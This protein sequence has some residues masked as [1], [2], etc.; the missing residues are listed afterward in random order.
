MTR[1]MYTTSRVHKENVHFMQRPLL[2][3]II[4]TS[5]RSSTTESSCRTVQR[6]TF[7]LTSLSKYR[8]KKSSRND[9]PFLKGP[10][11][12]TTTTF[13]S[14]TLSSSKISSRAFWLSSNLWSCVGKAIKIGRPPN[15]FASKSGS[16]NV[17]IVPCESNEREANK[18]FFL[19]FISHTIKYNKYKVSYA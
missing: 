2:S 19:L 15:N 1:V 3:N 9:F 4:N 14:R 7:F 13:L 8:K 16:C 10:A 6:L 18:Q 11:T 17:A 5:D 12:D